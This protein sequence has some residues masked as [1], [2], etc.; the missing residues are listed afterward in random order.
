MT[1]YAQCRQDKTFIQ[2]DEPVRFGSLLVLHV[3]TCEH[4]GKLSVTESEIKKAI[5]MYFGIDI[6]RPLPFQPQPQQPTNPYGR[7]GRV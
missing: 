6:D 1:Y 3:V 2:A 4:Q 7:F 5:F